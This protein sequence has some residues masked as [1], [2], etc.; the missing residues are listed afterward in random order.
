M[1]EVVPCH[2]A[3]VPFYSNSGTVTVTLASQKPWVVNG[4]HSATYNY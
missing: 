3:K 2:S 1:I 4:L